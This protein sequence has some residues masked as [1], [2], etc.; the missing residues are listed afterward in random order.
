[1]RQMASGLQRMK[2]ALQLIA[3]GKGDERDPAKR[4]LP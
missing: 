3:A 4:T 2:D 1:M